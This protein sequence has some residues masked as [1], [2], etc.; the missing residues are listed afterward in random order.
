VKEMVYLKSI[1]KITPTDVSVSGT[2][3]QK[4]HLKEFRGG[5]SAL[6][7]PPGSTYGFGV[8][9]V[10]CGTHIHLLAPWATRL[11]SQCMPHWWQVNGNTARDYSLAS[12]RQHW[13]RV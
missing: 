2:I 10:V 8:S 5:G 9:R 6:L 1:Q 3:Y 11:L 13:A 12:T 7:A 4:M